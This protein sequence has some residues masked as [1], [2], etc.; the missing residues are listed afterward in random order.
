MLYSLPPTCKKYPVPCS[1]E[2]P[3]S[4][5]DHG[6]VQTKH[7]FLLPLLQKLQDRPLQ[8]SIA[9]LPFLQAAIAKLCSH[10][11]MVLPCL[12]SGECSCA[13]GTHL[14]A[15]V[16]IPDKLK[17]RMEHYQNMEHRHLIEHIKIGRRRI[18]IILF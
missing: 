8:C 4:L 11:Q 14:R 3:L 15:N 2:Y 6:K 7:H 9:S 1:W 5:F 16:D 10:C 17:K 13:R 18:R 12:L